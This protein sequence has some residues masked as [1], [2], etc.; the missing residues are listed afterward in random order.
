M[1]LPL[2]QLVAVLEDIAPT[3][4]AEPWDNVGLL[5][6]DPSQT[7][8]GV[9]LTVD[10]TPPVA[11]EARQTQCNTVVAYH[12]PIF[13]NLKRIVAPDPMF[14]AI[15]DGIAIYSV[16]TALDIAEGGTNDALADALGLIERAP[17]R[18]RPDNE[19]QGLGR[20]G[21]LEPTA[22]P[23]LFER[24]RHAL[25]VERILVAGPT[26]GEVRKAAVCAGSCGE[27]F[28]DALLQK[29]DLYLT[30][31]M[32]HHHALEAARAGMTIVAVLHSNSER[33]AL[34]RL[35]QT[36]T[37]RFPELPVLVSRADRDPFVIQ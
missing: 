24:I 30:G 23:V 33:L 3:Y 34:E 28:R 12:P 29:V 11:A 8:T 20:V 22:R 14:E 4:L 1:Q 25:G 9:L 32:R 17:L 13:E 31:E 37:E 27:L 36:L 15:R 26:T 6:G 10:Y 21:T 19:R 5:V 35:K 18:P 2:Q 7:V 16:H